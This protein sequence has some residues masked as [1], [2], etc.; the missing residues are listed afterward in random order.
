MRTTI[1]ISWQ[2]FGFNG[3]V[4]TIHLYGKN[5]AEWNPNTQ[6]FVEQNQGALCKSP[7]GHRGQGRHRRR[8]AFPRIFG[9]S[10]GA[11]RERDLP[12]LDARLSDYFYQYGPLHGDGKCTGTENSVFKDGKCRQIKGRGIA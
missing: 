1:K 9:T 8:A 11:M 12:G 6:Q 2:P 7:R 10:N 3:G 4:L 5:E